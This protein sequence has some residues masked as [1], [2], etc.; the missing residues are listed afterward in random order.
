MCNYI[1]TKKGWLLPCMILLSAAIIA[2]FNSPDGTET[3][4]DAFGSAGGRVSSTNFETAFILGQSSPP[5][6]SESNN[7]RNIGG[8]FASF[9]T[10]GPTDKWD[11]TGH[12]GY[13]ANA[14]PVD[15]AIVKVNN[16]FLD[17]TDSYGDYGLIDLTTDNYVV[18]PE[19][20]F[21]TGSAIS[22]FDAAWILQ[23]GVG[24]RTFT[25][26]QLIAGD[27]SGNGSVS[28]F[29]AAKV[30]QYGVGMI[31]QFPVMPD[32]S[33]FW[34]FVPEDFPIS[35][36]NW[37]IAPDSIAYN[38]LTSDTTDNYFG[39][40]YGDVSGNWHP[41]DE[42]LA[43]TT[44]ASGTVDI[45]LEDIYG[46]PGDRISLPIYLDNGS[47][48]IAMSFTLVYDPQVLKALRVV[49]P[50]SLTQDYLIAHEVK[51]GQ[52]QVAL[53]GSHAIV[54]TG[55]VVNLEFEVLETESPEA[56]SLLKITEMVINEGGLAA[57]IQAAEF[58][59][60][61]PVPEE[62]ALDQ[63]YPN[64]FN[65]QTLIKY[66]LPKPGKVVLK[67]YNTLGHEVRALVN[68][69]Q[70]AGY[71]EICWDGKDQHGLPVSSGLYFYQFKA[72]KFYQVR[73]MNLIR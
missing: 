56:G 44:V 67:I 64:P 50:T 49:S 70:E 45:R 11:I 62:Y 48:I 39:I 71:H 4:S 66:Q 25:P 18:R 36:S 22:A 2:A 57:N 38:P 51:E 7:Y 1:K 43:K 26:Y 30:L 24:L 65:A 68:E 10:V 9:L 54:G 28:A 31:N 63:N 16:V 6:V 52:I 8:F 32:N 41:S 73:K 61:V 72:G 14:D 34:R 58:K 60:G 47:D 53:A 3:K 13:Y 40:I 5:D 33:H 19:K 15:D 23:Y 12:I 35:Q 59:P 37:N 21:D 20:E 55:A 27:V 42:G 29:D 46:K 69:D 17:T